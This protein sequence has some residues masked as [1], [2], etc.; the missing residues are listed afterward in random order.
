[1]T[2]GNTYLLA[3]E[4]KGTEYPIVYSPGDMEEVFAA[5]ERADLA[6]GKPVHRPGVSY[7]DMRVTARAVLRATK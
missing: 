4:T 3:I 7:V 5:D 6:Q 1:M 2:N